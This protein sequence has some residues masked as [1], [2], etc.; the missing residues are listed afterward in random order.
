ML[1]F[2]LYHLYST[3]SAFDRWI[4]ISGS[5]LSCLLDLQLFSS[6]LGGFSCRWFAILARLPCCLPESY[7]TSVGCGSLA[8]PDDFSAS[9]VHYSG[10]APHVVTFLLEGLPLQLWETFFS[11]LELLLGPSLS[12]CLFGRGQLLG[13]PSS[14]A[15]NTSICLPPMSR[16]YLPEDH[17][18]LSLLNPSQWHIGNYSGNCPYNYFLILVC[19]FHVHF[20]PS[21]YVADGFFIL[22]RWGFKLLV[23]GSTNLSFVASFFWLTLLMKFSP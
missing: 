3:R 11:I 18:R 9:L 15:D 4:S 16:T 2:V 12:L 6:H 5:N 21:Q 23:V 19:L 13:I 1:F 7:K 8:L 17:W 20:R 14:G 22:I 10:L